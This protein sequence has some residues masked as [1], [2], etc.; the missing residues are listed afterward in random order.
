MPGAGDRLARL[1]GQEVEQKV[2]LGGVARQ[3]EGLVRGPRPAVVEPD[4]QV[5]AGHDLLILPAVAGDHDLLHAAVGVDFFPEADQPLDG[6]LLLGEA[7]VWG[8]VQACRD[9]SRPEG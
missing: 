7:G 9:V 3:L 2:P 6:D 1:A 8:G 5:G 4:A